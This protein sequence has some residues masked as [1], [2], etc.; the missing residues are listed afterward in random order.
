MFDSVSVLALFWEP[1]GFT[2]EAWGPIIG[3]S[4]DGAAI[5]RKRGVSPLPFWQPFGS[6]LAPKWLQGEVLEAIRVFFVALVPNVVFSCFWDRFLEGL[7]L[8]NQ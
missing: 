5:L 7:E 4:C 1:V 2:S 6:F 3:K 8:Q